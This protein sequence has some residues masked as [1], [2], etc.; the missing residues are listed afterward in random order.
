MKETITVIVPVYNVESYLDRCV[1]S[2]LNQTYPHLQVML[3]DDGS[4]D[5]SGDICDCFARQDPR[6]QVIHKANGGPASARKAGLAKAEGEYIGFVDAD[7]YIESN[8]YEELLAHLICTDVDFVYSGYV[9]ESEFG[10]T[11]YLPKAERVFRDF[12]KC[13]IISKYFL[14]KEEPDMVVGSLWAKLY[15]RELIVAACEQVPETLRYGEDILGICH[16]IFKSSTFSIKKEAYYHYTF[17]RDSLTCRNGDTI[18]FTKIGD[19]HRYLRDAFKEYGC[20][21]E[22]REK[23]DD[24]LIRLISLFLIPLGNARGIFYVPYYCYPDINGIL[25]K[26]MIIYGAGSVGQDYYARFCKY[27]SCE[28]VALADTYPEKYDLEYT[29]V[30]GLQDLTMLE[31]DVVIIAVMSQDMMCEIKNSL[32]AVGIPENKIIWKKP[33]FVI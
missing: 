8:M 22:L 11:T 30:V 18:I 19:L 5:T 3:I 10:S 2:I 15:K 9:E 32:L 7:D 12:D 23:Q 29:E 14:G 6:V 20:F 26:K 21:E 24:Y 31:F 16:C 13:E 28:I 33:E 4:T 1:K 17:R 27:S 25:G